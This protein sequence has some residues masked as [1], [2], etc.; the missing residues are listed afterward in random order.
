MGH[1]KVPLGA[2]SVQDA[3]WNEYLNES[4]KK[5]FNGGGPVNYICVSTQPAYVQAAGY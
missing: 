1:N 2:Q 3:A 5:P 4:P